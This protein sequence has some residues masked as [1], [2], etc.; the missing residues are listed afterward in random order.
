MCPEDFSKDLEWFR[1][2]VGGAE[3][4]PLVLQ[5]GTK[6]I[7]MRANRWWSSGSPSPEQSKIEG[8]RAS[9]R[10]CPLFAALSFC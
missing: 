4:L 6:R 7:W 10:G 8:G 2:R 1:A 9:R 3:F 5:I